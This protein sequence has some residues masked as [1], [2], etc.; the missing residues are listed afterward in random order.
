MSEP[1]KVSG[2]GWRT[3]VPARKEAPTQSYHVEPQAKPYDT[4]LVA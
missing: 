3:A 2:F 1:D 4:D